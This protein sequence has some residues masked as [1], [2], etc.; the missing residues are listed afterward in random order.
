MSCIFFGLCWEDCNIC[1][2]VAEHRIH[3]VQKQVPIWYLV[4]KDLYHCLPSSVNKFVYRFFSGDIS[5]ETK[6]DGSYFQEARRH[7]SR[8]LGATLDRQQVGSLMT[9]FTRLFLPRTV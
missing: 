7:A 2:V 5:E 3:L 8:T 9:W 4:C 6:E 1:N